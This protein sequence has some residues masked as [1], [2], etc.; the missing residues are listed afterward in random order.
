MKTAFF[1]S[2]KKNIKKISSRVHCFKWHEKKRNSLPSSFDDLIPPLSDLCTYDA[3]TRLKCNNFKNNK[4]MDFFSSPQV[5]MIIVLKETKKKSTSITV[6]ECLT[7]QSRHG[8]SRILA[9]R[10]IS[11]AS[12]FSVLF[13]FVPY[14]SK[15]SSATSEPLNSKNSPSLL[16]VHLSFRCSM[17]FFLPFL[18]CC[19]WK[20]TN[21]STFYCGIGS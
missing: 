5:K 17:S 4:S 3:K 14:F 11:I 21:W 13:Y 15:L 20:N 1:N 16:P 12:F 7:C 6:D 19:E 9:L 2:Y 8:V 18:L 10:P